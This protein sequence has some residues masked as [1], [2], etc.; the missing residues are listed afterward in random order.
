MKLKHKILLGYGIV[1]SL[2]VFVGGWGTINLRRLGQASDAILRENYRSIL[3]AE[4]II[5]AIERQ[6]SAVLLALLDNQ[7]Q[8]REQF[9][10][11]EILF[12]QWLGRAKDNI[13]IA[14]EEEILT[15]LEKN[16][17]D[18]LQA[19]SW[20]DITTESYYETIFPLFETV[21]KQS[22]QLRDLNQETM[23]AASESARR[24]SQ[25]AIWSMAIAGGGAVA[26][27]L[28]FSLL[29][30]DRIVRPLRKM[31][32]A[33]EKIAEG[34]YDV[35]V[36]VNSQDELG[37]L[38]REINS[39]SQ[40]LKAFHEL[41]ISKVIIEQQR[42]EAIIQSIGDGIIV[43]DEELKIIAL[44]PTA[45]RLVNINPKL[46][47]NHNF[48]DVFDNDRLYRYLQ[49]TIET[50]Q[51][52]QLE[53]KENILSVK[54]DNKV[55]YYRYTITPV[56]T[57]NNKTIG[58]IVLL[59]N[60]TKLKEIDQLKSEFVATASHELRT[61]LTGMAMSLNLL[62][63]TAQ[64]K[65]SEPEKELLTTANEDVERLR[66][67][68]N[69]LLDLS[70]IESGRIDLEFTPVEV[71]FLLKKATST[72]NIQ[73]NNK[74]ITLKIEDSNSLPKANIDAN[75]ILWVLTNLIVNAIRYTDNGG[76]ITLKAKQNRDWIYISV[77]DN[78]AGIPREYKSKIFDKFVQVKTEKDVGGSG[79]GLAICKEIVKA[80][81]GTI[82]VD[83]TVGE[84][85]TF[86]FTVPIIT[87]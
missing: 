13:T 76:E 17:R 83:S 61:P 26:F 27:G 5:D 77:R 53:E 65:L 66:S 57:K 44:N 14:G 22:I 84:G 4:N 79:L 38:A 34:N 11:G 47:I 3:A 49:E 68:V 24:I 6:D 60:I 8:A 32:I 42:N 31:T 20:T 87:S 12:L 54:L 67:L 1:I 45:A 72:L 15:A 10:Q 74:N 78:G 71:E 51:I 16:Y 73:A 41:N 7:T 28:I 35:A 40:K 64:S 39:M 46:A 37:I 36:K 2:I 63:E 86:T 30:C 69:D 21:R 23:V 55:Q 59:Q 29:L 85:S 33:T 56:I 58:G 43:V 19:V 52:P 25:Q 50:S 80:H 9:R 81:G 82:W 75:K 70:K 62:Q 18:Y 48:L